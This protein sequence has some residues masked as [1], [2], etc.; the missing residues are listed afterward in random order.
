MLYTAVLKAFLTFG[1]L[2]IFHNPLN[3]G[4]EPDTNGY[5]V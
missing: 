3:N 4:T 5:G 2:Q 1:M